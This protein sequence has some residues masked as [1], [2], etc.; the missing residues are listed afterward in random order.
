VTDDDNKVFIIVIMDLDINL[1]RYP[2]VVESVLLKCKDV[3]TLDKAALVCKLWSNITM[4]SKFWIT[5]LKAS[6]AQVPE[7]VLNNKN[8]DWKVFR[9]FYN[10]WSLWGEIP[11]GT[12]L[13]QDQM[14]WCYTCF[15]M[16]EHQTVNLCSEHELDPYIM[17]NYQPGILIKDSWS[18]T[19]GHKAFFSIEAKIGVEGKRCFKEFFE[20]NQ[21]DAPNS[22]RTVKHVFRD[23]GPGVRQVWL[24]RGNCNCNAVSA[25]PFLM[26]SGAGGLRRRPTKVVVMWP[27]ATAKANNNN[28]NNNEKLKT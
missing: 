9:S 28:N 3:S 5:K 1:N 6:K 21:N 20:N 4:S 14:W 27:T 19:H 16:E 18:N 24:E 17:D 23:Y 12:N 11:F 15:Q 22:T 8:L 2:M 7:E 10:S 25:N 13:V 26:G